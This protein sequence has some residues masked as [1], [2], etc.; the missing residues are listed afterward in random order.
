MRVAALAAALLAA[1]VLPGAPLG[2]GVPI[3]AALV[4]VAAATS[5]RP[6]ADAV[7]AGAGALALAAIPAVLDAGWVVAIDLAAAWLLACTAVAGPSVAARRNVDRWSGTGRLDVAYLRTLSA[8]AAP[9][10]AK[11]PPDLRE[12]SLAAL[13]DRLAGGDPWSSANLSRRRARRLLSAA[14]SERAAPAPAS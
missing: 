8:D 6:S 1:A 14:L 13:S 4:A 3:V 11:L 5:T 9:A 10:L 2:V 7:A 12:Q